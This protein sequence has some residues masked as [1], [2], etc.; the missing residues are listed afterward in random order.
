TS[1]FVLQSVDRSDFQYAYPGSML[2]TVKGFDTKE[3]KSGINDVTGK[4]EL[5]INPSADHQFTAGAYAIHYEF[6]P[7]SITLNEESQVG[8]IYLDEGL[9]EDVFFSSFTV[10][11]TE[12][13]LYFEDKWQANDRLLLSSGIHVSGFFVQDTHYLDPQL[14]LS[15]DYLL[16]PKLALNVGYSRMAQYLHNLTSSSI[17]L[18]TDLWVPTTAKVS[19]A[20]SDQYALSARW[21]VTKAFTID[22]SSYW[23]NMRH[24]ISY[25]EGASFLLK[26][27]LLPASIVDAANWESKITRG[28]GDASGVELELNY[29]QKRFQLNW[30]GT[31]S[32]SYRTF[33]DINNGK[34]YPDRYDRRWSS[35]FTGTFHVSPKW[36]I[37][38]DFIYGSGIAITLAES[39]F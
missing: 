10:K 5:D 1:S 29:E 2:D 36:T 32:R 11:A 30:N 7:K 19:P 23:K 24:L 8:A 31:W 38:A 39:K 21:R 34:P 17:G 28:I 13:G 6:H 9:L 22:L 3:F 4:V 35:S 27:G 15:L 25:Q 37:G 26:E 33:E 14:R 12:G 20:L 16:T 18:P